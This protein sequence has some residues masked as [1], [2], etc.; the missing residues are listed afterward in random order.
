MIV[1]PAFLVV[2]LVVPKAAGDMV[3]FFLPN[4]RVLE[5]LDLATLGGLLLLEEWE[6]NAFLIPSAV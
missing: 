4:E 6:A 2:Y 1:V 5:L 3:D